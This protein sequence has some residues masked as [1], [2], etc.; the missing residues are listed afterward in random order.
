M[1]YFSFVLHLKV[2]FCFSIYKYIVRL[3]MFTI[4]YAS[5]YEKLKKIKKRKYVLLIGFY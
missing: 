3:K 4:K 5:E 1:F 2:I